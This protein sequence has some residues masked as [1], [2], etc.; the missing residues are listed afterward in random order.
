MGST[1]SWYLSRFIA[2]GPAEIVHRVIEK[3]KKLSWRNDERGWENYSKVDDGPLG[4]FS[5]MRKRLAK[6]SAVL[7]DTTLR[8]L[9]THIRMGELVFLG[10]RWPEDE[11]WFAGAPSPKIWLRDPIKGLLWPGADTYCFSINFRHRSE[12]FGDVKYVWEFNRLQFLH[13]S[14]AYIAATGDADQ[15]RWVFRILASW[16]A[17]NPPYR[18]INWASGIELSLRLITFALVIAAV[19]PSTMERD[20][21]IMMRR[22]I[23][24]HGYWLH[25]YPSLGSSAN[26]HLIAEGVGL[27]VAGLLAPDLP[28]ASEWQKIGKDI[29]ERETLK[30]ILDD[31]VGAEQSPTYQAFIMEMIALAAVLADDVGEAFSERTLNRLALGAEYLDWSLDGAGFAPAI[32]DNDEGRAI[33]QPPYYEPRYVASVVTA[34]AGLTKRDAVPPHDPHIRDAIFS[35]PTKQRTALEGLRIFPI[36]GY[37]IVRDHI[38][39]RAVDLVFDHGPLGYLSLAAHGHADALSIWLTIDGIPVFV[40][41]GTYLYHSGGEM[42]NMLRETKGHNTLVVAGRSQSRIA[43]PFMWSAK[44]RASLIDLRPWPDWSVTAMQDGYVHAFG[45]RHVRRLERNEDEIVIWDQLVGSTQS[46]PAC[47]Q[48][49]CNSSLAVIPKDDAVVISRDGDHIL[50]ILPPVGFKIKVIIGD[51]TEGLGWHSPRFGT[52]VAA[53]LVTLQGRPSSHKICTRLR[54]VG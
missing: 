37:S 48:F 26:N 21:R 3:A 11:S 19:G 8:E 27:L 17:A 29:I 43:G 4:S 40:D 52:L 35:A 12:S 23:A 41:A 44:A 25:R 51:K 46:L 32:G 50:E 49:L 54:V 6:A 30:Q 13:S 38:N 7:G 5:L 42:R 18:G 36:G 16:M 47:V 33:A 53:P 22:L 9:V 31:G 28:Q 10:A 34:I 24:A 15:T 2:M 1:V 45:V 39:G 20:E 14:T